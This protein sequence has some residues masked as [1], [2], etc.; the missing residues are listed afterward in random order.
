M[1]FFNDT[2]LDQEVRRLQLENGG[3]GDTSG[4]SGTSASSETLLLEQQQASTAIAPTRPRQG[5]DNLI[6][7]SDHNHSVNTWWETAP[8]ST[9]KD[10]ECANVYAYPPIAPVTIADAA[11]TNGSPNLSSPSNPFT[12]GMVGRY[13]Q[14]T[15]AGVAAATLVARVITFTDSGHIVLDTN[16][17]TTV[18][19]ASARLNL[20]RLG[21][22]NKL[23]ASATNPSDALKDASHSQIG[24]NIADPDWQKLKGI[25]RIGDT[26][27]AGYTL[28]RFNST[29]AS[30]VALHHLL[31]G[32]EPFARLNIVRA[33]PYVRVM[34]R[35][36]IGLYNN[37]DL[38]LDFIK[39]SKFVA[40]ATLDPPVPSATVST[41]YLVVVETDQGFTL[42]SQVL[43]V[44]APTDTAMAQGAR[45]SLAWTFF[46]GAVKTSVYRRRSAG[47]VFLMES[48]ESGANSWT[49]V[50]LTSRID[51]GSAAFPVYADASDTISSYW[52]SAAGEFDDLPY[53]GEPGKFWKPIEITLPF[54]PSVDMA[55]VF[56]PVLVVGLTEPCATELN[57]VETTN[58]S[59]DVVSPAAQFT[60]AM[61]GKTATL[62]KA[63]GTVVVST[64]VSAY[65]DSS[66]VTLTAPATWTETGA[67]LL[68][69]DSQ[70]HGLFYDCVGLSLQQGEW[71]INPE[72]NGE[73][74][75][76]TVAAS[77]NGSTQGGIG[78]G[79]PTGG[80]GTGGIDCVW[81][82][83]I[84]SVMGRERNG[85]FYELLRLVL[86]I[87]RVMFGRYGVEQ[88]R[89]AAVTLE[90]RV[91][92]GHGYGLD[93]FN[94]V[95]AISWA[96][97]DEISWLETPSRRLPCTRWH[98][99]VAGPSTF[100]AGIKVG[101]L[102]RGKYVL[103][104]DGKTPRLEPV[105]RIPRESGL[106]R[107]V[108]FR[109]KKTGRLRQH[110][111][112]VNR[113]VSH[114]RKNDDGGLQLNL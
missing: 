92:D 75:G 84:V 23:Y 90:D 110:L 7:N 21:H 79:D 55:H 111:L 50:N 16:A 98:R 67:T 48:F 91:W 6:R 44:N 32:R 26:A 3:P 80:G 89:A 38:A 99:V 45:I 52:A 76:Q 31:A 109:L 74:R 19:A 85:F 46:A 43:T 17:S 82:E 94:E 72:D 30:Y 112:V 97:V 107:V 95:E 22:T 87:F 60:P 102:V 15:G 86:S 58:T 49:D 41:D 54:S 83:A 42:L 9:D 100:K 96:V 47:N 37:Y 64:T 27:I 113:L 13:V 106:F 5:I 53:D 59:G 69:E 36:F 77:P 71:A 35:L 20:Q 70:P 1:T 66:H 33:N 8:S 12:A 88:R 104:S 73:L 24:S 105:L 51:T 4:T 81:E 56:D 62:T 34:G 14:V 61:V 25:V 101:H 11:I 65:A 63:D 114:N 68:I 108:S 2:Q 78:G 29:G 10:L 18:A 28:G 103:I 40:G 57:D 39:G 93:N